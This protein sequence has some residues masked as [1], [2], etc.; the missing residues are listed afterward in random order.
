MNRE[1]LTTPNAL[2]V[3]LVIAAM[4]MISAAGASER[5]RDPATGAAPAHHTATAPRHKHA[6]KPAPHKDTMRHEH[7]NDVAVKPLTSHPASS[8]DK[9]SE[10]RSMFGPLS[11]EIET[12]TNVKRRSLAGG[13]ADSDRDP[14]PRT[15][16][17][18]FLGLSLK[19]E[20]SW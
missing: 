13:E 16:L 9:S 12:S 1:S 11:F 20:F 14:T 15:V 6:A 3:T 5:P 18:D 17:P 4:Q 2:C 8:S 10:R 19:S 7:K